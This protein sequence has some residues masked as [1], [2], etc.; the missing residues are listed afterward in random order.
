MGTYFNT[1]FFH[2]VSNM[3]TTLSTAEALFFGSGLI[4][5]VVCVLVFI[6]NLE[7]LTN[8]NKKEEE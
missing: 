1:G 8:S 6:K 3:L 4:M 5:W 7:I 2:D